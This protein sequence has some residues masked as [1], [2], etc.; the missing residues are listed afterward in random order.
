MSQTAA[1]SEHEEVHETPW[2]PAALCI[3]FPYYHGYIS[4]CHSNQ[5]MNRDVKKNLVGKETG[6]E[7]GHGRSDL[8]T[9]PGGSGTSLLKDAR[10]C[11]APE[12][13]GF[14]DLLTSWGYCSAAVSY[15]IPKL[16]SCCEKP[17]DLSGVHQLRVPRTWCRAVAVQ[18]SG[19]TPANHPGN[20][21]Q[22]QLWIL[23]LCSLGAWIMSGV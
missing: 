23:L 9:N 10:P 20:V 19:C 5:D 1:P 11:P 21:P 14:C 17:S 6:P 2:G 3:S 15:L 12:P 7:A 4:H 18:R 13:S 8:E 16:W 22:K